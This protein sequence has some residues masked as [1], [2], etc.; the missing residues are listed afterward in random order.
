MSDEDVEIEIGDIDPDDTHTEG[1]DQID[2]SQVEAGQEQ[3][4][5]INDVED[6][7]ERTEA[8]ARW[9]KELGGETIH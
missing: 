5:A 2:F 3:V 4:D 8:A 7:D 6:E 1:D 9:A